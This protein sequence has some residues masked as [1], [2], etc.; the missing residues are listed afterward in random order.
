LTYFLG[1]SKASQIEDGE[2]FSL[3]FWSAGDEQAATGL[4]IS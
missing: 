3:L 1:A 2:H 4:W